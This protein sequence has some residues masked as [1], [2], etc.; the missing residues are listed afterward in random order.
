[1]HRLPPPWLAAVAVAVATAVATVGAGCRSAEKATAATA[2]PLLWAAHKDGKTTHLLGTMHV[3]FNAEKQLPGWVWDKVRAA[4]SFAVETDISDPALSSAAVRRDGKNLRQE[5]GEEHWSKLEKLLGAPTARATLNMT[6]GAVTSLL[7]IKGLPPAMPMDLVLLGEAESADKK[8]VFLEPAALQIKLLQKWLDVRALKDLIDER[9]AG[10]QTSKDLLAAY[11]AGDIVRIEKLGNDREAFLETG[12]TVAEY[13]AMMDE[14][15][16]QRNASW[17][18]PIEKMHA[19]GDAMVAVGAM[20]LIGERSVLALLEA[21]GYRI[22]RV[23]GPS[24]K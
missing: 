9:A 21:R 6:P 22:E 17:I 14:M 8:V 20:H 23:Q 24:A 11:L 19:E 5:L 4:K 3:G 13:D 12:R 7:E 2:H 16:Y 15:L 18:A 1:M 10:K